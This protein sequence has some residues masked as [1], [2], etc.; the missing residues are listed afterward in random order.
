MF[1]IGAVMLASSALLPPY[2]QNLAGYSVTDTGMLMAP[3]GVG[4]MI[5]DDVRRPSRGTLRSAHADDGGNAPAAVVDVGHVATGRPDIATW[6]LVTSTF[7]QGIGMGFV[8]VPM[9]LVGV[10]DALAD[11]SHRRLRADQSDAQHRQR[12][13]RFRHDDVPGGQHP[14]GARA[15]RRARDPVQSCTGTERTQ[16][17][18]ESPDPVRLRMRLDRVIES[19]RAGHRL[20]ERLPVHVLSSAFRRLP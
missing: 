18:D 14:D 11:L 7:V 9:N 20:R 16:H 17:D 8:F 6:H 13:R 2:L 3:R 1:V 12:H 19:K 15:A 10:R 5:R 4:T